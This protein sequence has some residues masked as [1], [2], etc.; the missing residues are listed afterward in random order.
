MKLPR[1]VRGGCDIILR[2]LLHQVRNDID[3]RGGEHA[4]QVGLREGDAERHEPNPERHG[5]LVDAAIIV[6]RKE[7]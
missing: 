6:L 4:P 1:S 5:R 3:R 7:R 2:A